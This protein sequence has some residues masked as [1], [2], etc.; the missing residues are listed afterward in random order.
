MNATLAVL[1][2]AKYLTQL[3]LCAAELR[4]EAE[5][6]RAVVRAKSLFP[7]NMPYNH[8]QGEFEKHYGLFEA[9]VAALDAAAQIAEAEVIPC[10]SDDTKTW[11]DIEVAS[12]AKDGT[13]RA[14]VVTERGILFMSVSVE[15]AVR[16]HYCLSRQQKA[17]ETLGTRQVSPTTEVAGVLSEQDKY[18]QDAAYRAIITLLQGVPSAN[19]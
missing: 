10:T 14:V 12:N 17:L 6:Q 7:R 13:Q 4:A 9:R 8:N 11:R 15:D 1:S 19:C 16:L 5:V 18:I 2:K 3:Q